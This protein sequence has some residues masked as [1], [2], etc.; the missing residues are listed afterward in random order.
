MFHLSFLAHCDS[1]VS[2][3]RHTSC[4]INFLP[5]VRSTGHIFCPIITKLGQNVCLDEISDE[6]ENRS[7]PVKN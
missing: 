6:F 2:V 1:D 3:V 5:C 4:H 7:C